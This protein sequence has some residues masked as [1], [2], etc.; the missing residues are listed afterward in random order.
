MPRSELAFRF[1]GAD[2]I[3]DYPPDRRNALRTQV[4][5]AAVIM[6]DNEWTTVAASV[7]DISEGGARLMT[8]C[9]A[10][11]PATFTLVIP[12]EN[13][14][15]PA[16]TAWRIGKELGVKFIGERRPASATH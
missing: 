4:D 1:R 5:D 2:A 10:E 13:V 12:S 8:A 16:R 11:L 7:Q 9:V 15:V 6:F 3:P 14:A